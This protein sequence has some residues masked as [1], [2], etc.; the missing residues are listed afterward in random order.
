MKKTLTLITLLGLSCAVL[1]GQTHYTV[2]ITNP[3]RTDC[4]HTGVT[5]DLSKTGMNVRSAYLTEN[6]KEIP[7]QLDDTDGNGTYDELFFYT[8]MKKKSSKQLELSLLDYGQPRSYKAEVY[9]DMM[10]T[11]KKIKESNK[12]SPPW[13][14]L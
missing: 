1:K 2:E 3:N 12:P 11:N 8:D 5:V 13:L 10:L 14:R 9:A 7:C 6:G 4:Q